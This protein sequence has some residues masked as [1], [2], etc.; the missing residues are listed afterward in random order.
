MGAMRLWVEAD[1]ARIACRRCRRV[2]TEQVPWARP[3]ARHT[4]DFEQ[5][6]GWLAQRMDKTA[7]AAVKRLV[8]DHLEPI[9]GARLDGL[10][11]IGVDEISYKRGHQYLTV[12]ADHDTGRVVWVAGERS[13]DAV[14]EFLDALGPERAGQVEAVTLDGSSIYAPVLAEGLPEA[15]LCL[16]PF[17]VTKW[18][19]EALDKVYAAVPAR[20]AVWDGKRYTRVH[21]RR[22]R[23]A[24]RTGGENLDLAQRELVN[25]VRRSSH[26]LWRAWQL[27]EEFRHLY[28]LD[29]PRHARAYLRY[30]CSK[31][32][33]SKIPE[34]ATL[35]TRLEKHSWSPT[36]P[37]ARLTHATGLSA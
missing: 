4:R 13:P 34:F 1:I 25:A 2:W 24:L 27:K 31:A 8:V 10:Y 33:R 7:I 35:V 15:R 32:L 21:W 6:I 12:V 29:N 5:M 3:T 26:R 37:A 14:Q 17:H 20:P 16:D 9:D 11:R 30:W 36:R 28:R 22:T 18:V 19:H 23:T